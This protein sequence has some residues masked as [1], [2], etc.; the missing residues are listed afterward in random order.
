MVQYELILEL[1]EFLGEHV[2]TCFFT[3]Y[4]LEHMGKK[5]SDYS[6]LSELDLETDSCI[7]M[8]PKLYDEKSARQHIKRVNDILT[9]PCVLN[10]QQNTPEEDKLNEIFEQG[11]K[12]GISEEDIL[13]KQEDIFKTI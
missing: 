13:K 6:D 9:T 11:K 8:R 5:L 4:F 7:Y 1:R 12:D 10:A 2:Y 3:N